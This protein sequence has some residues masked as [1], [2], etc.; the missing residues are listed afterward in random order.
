MEFHVGGTFEITDA[1]NK[2]ATIA[3]ITND[4]VY[5]R[6]TTGGSNDWA[7][8]TMKRMFESGKFI[9]YK[10]PVQEYDFKVGDT[11]FSNESDCLCTIINV[12]EHNLR[13]DRV[14]KSQFVRDIKNTLDFFRRGTYHSYVSIKSNQSNANGTKDQTQDKTRTSDTVGRAKEFGS[15]IASSI[16]GQVEHG[17]R[18]PGNKIQGKTV[19]SRIVS[20]ESRPCAISS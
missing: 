2:F 5:Y 20:I 15:A 17:E 10:P 19:A 11:F 1:A 14:G 13:M 9:N 4:R 18:Y 3:S 8:E 6:Y 7:I 16:R 12:T